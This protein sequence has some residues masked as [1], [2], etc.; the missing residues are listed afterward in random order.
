MKLYFLALL[1]DQ[2]IQDEVTGFKQLAQER[3]GT[4]QALKSPAHIT[5]IPPFRTEQTDFSALQPMARAQDP[6]T[7]QLCHFDRFG[8]RVIFVDVVP[9]PILLS[10]QKRLADFCDRQLEITSDSRP[11][12]PHMTVAFK[13]LKPSVFPDAWDYFSAQAY[14]RTFTARGVTLLV[15]T[16]QRWLV[17]RTFAFSSVGSDGLSNESLL[18]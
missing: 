1:P 16:G 15:H 17:D 7:V 3:F 8:S 18:P 14:E 6:F 4:S 11:F 13:D 10:Y 9:E 12:H 5:L 2:G